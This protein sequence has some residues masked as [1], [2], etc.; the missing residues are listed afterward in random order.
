MAVNAKI[1]VHGGKIHLDDLLCAAM[2]TILGYE[3]ARTLDKEI[4]SKCSSVDIVCDIGRK[5]DGVRFFDHHQPD[6]PFA[7]D[8]GLNTRFPFCK[9][10][11][12]GQ[13]WAAK[14]KDIIKAIDPRTPQEC[15]QE[16]VDAID[17]LLIAPSDRI[18]TDGGVDIPPGICTLSSVISMCNPVSQ[19]ST[20]SDDEFN[21]LLPFVV[22]ILKSYV[23]KSLNT[24]YGRKLVENAPI[25]DEKIIVLDRYTPW[26]QAVVSNTKFDN[27]IY[28]VYPSNRG[29][30]NAQCIPNR[31]AKGVRKLFPVEWI[32]NSTD[33][34]SAKAMG[35]EKQYTSGDNF[36]CHEDRW[37]IAVPTKEMAIDACRKA[38]AME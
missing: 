24:I 3:P 13:L 29:G 21:T 14:G 27:C 20:V 35:F 6:S 5:Y 33:F 17:L 16:T 38:C 8:C 23:L 11:A 7:Q 32:G 19:D 34:D 30:W 25:V 18:D 28:C 15:L 12:A 2:G 31:G 22:H 4:C 36:F 10:A 26:S 1:Y 37:L 9:V